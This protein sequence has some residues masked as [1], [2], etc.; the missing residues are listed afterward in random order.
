MTQRLTHSD[1]TL[2]RSAKHAKC[3]VRDPAQ[4]PSP[5]RARLA[6]NRADCPRI[7]DGNLQALRPPELP[8][9]RRTRARPQAISI[10]GRA[11]WRASTTRLCAECSLPASRRVSCQLPQATGDAQRDLRDQ[12]RAS[13]SPR[14]PRLDGSSRRHLRLCQGGCHHRQHDRILPRWGRPATQP[15]RNRS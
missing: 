1:L 12:C 5:T 10:D 9:H 13:A 8:L 14:E 2:I 4:T 11:N 7:I 3:F 6:P 15:G